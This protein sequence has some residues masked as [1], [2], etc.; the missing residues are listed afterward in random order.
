MNG[1]RLVRLTLDS[2]TGVATEEILYQGMGRIRD[3]RQGPDG[4]IYLAI[5]DRGGAPTAIVRLMP[6]APQ[7]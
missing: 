1:Q 6:V 4:F 7:T 2:S 3:V 5:D